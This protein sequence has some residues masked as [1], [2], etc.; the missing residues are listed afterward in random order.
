MRREFPTLPGLEVL[1]QIGRGAT[2]SVYEA[3]RSADERRV[4]IKVVPID[5]RHDSSLNMRVEREANALRTLKHPNI[6]RM[7]DIHKTEHEYILELEYV[8]GC[9]LTKWIENNR[10]PLLEPKLWILAQLAQALAVAHMNGTIHRD[11][12]PDN[13]LVSRTGEIKLTDFGLAKQPDAID[14]KITQPGLLVGSLAYMAPE[15][16]S[17]GLSSFS[18]DIFSFGVIAYELLTGRHPFPHS[19]VKTL[20]DSMY[21][22]EASNLRLPILNQRLENI[23]RSCLAV[24][25]K[26]RPSSCWQ[27]FA[28]LMISLESSE[29]Q[30]LSQHLIT[31]E[32]VDTILLAQAMGKK[33][34]ELKSKIENQISQTSPDKKHLMQ[35]INE[36]ASIFPDD[37]KTTEYVNRLRAPEV[38]PNKQKRRLLIIPIVLACVTGA[39]YFGI[40]LTKQ[41]KLTTRPSALASPNVEQTNA[42]IAGAAPTATPTPIATMSPVTV[43][44][45]PAP[46]SVP[47][48]SSGI[49]TMHTP[50]DVRVFIDGIRQSSSALRSLRLTAGTHQI[51]MERD[52]FLPIE[53]TIVI[54]KNSVTKIRTSEPQAE[55]VGNE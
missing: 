17:D 55:A 11:L 3:I 37:Q 34:Q 25:M 39:V 54:K 44:P 43:A 13:V 9:T 10:I 14:C 50:P 18:S 35:L 29:I 42:V 36:L 52:N 20:I 46:P 53:R 8:D 28:E 24:D 33:H 26:L 6:V 22:S 27:I 21:S 41:E 12:K 49:L 4:A 2:S 15:V 5:F 38:T 51:L 7:Y 30:N 47:A 1:R 40:S 16:L 31:S 23:L 32:S 19:D 48:V 45:P